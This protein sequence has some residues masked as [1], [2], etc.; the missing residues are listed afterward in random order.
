MEKSV[1]SRVLKIWYHNDFIWKRSY[2]G[3]EM[4]A[5]SKKVFDFARKVKIVKVYFY[6]LTIAYFIDN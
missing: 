5:A 2:E 6:K 3:K 1:V 4:K